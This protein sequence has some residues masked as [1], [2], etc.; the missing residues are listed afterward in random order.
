MVEATGVVLAGGDS[1]RFGDANKAVATLDGRP[2]VAHV[3]G[4]VDAATEATP[5][6]AVRTDAQRADLEDALARPVRFVRDRPGGGPLAGLVAAA[7]AAETPELVVVGCDMPLAS[8]RVLR[9]L[10][11]ERRPAGRLDAVVACDAEGRPQPLHGAYATDLVA[12]LGVGEHDG[13]LD[14]VERAASR[15]R[16]VAPADAPPD[17]SLARSMT[18]VNTRADLRAVRRTD[19]ADDGVGTERPAPERAHRVFWD[20]LQEFYG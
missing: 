12:G 4:A 7:T 13:R 5:T 3:V 10:R 2:L 20:A 8:A 18:N 16:R 6:V 11:D 19:G 1:T 17:A 14:A 9:W 15:V